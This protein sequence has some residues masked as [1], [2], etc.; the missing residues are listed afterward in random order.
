MM[1]T[2]RR[3]GIECEGENRTKMRIV[4]GSEME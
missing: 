4:S 3:M 2:R 1:M